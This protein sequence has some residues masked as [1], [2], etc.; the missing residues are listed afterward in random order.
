MKTPDEIRAM[1][2]SLLDE[3]GISMA[4]ASIAIGKNSAY[5]QQYI[6]KGSPVRLPEE[7]RKRLSIILDIPEQDL[8]DR[9]IIKIPMPSAFE[10]INMVA[11]S[12][13]GLFAPKTD[14]NDKVSINMYD[15]TACCGTGIE[16]LAE[17]V[18]GTWSM[19]MP[20]FKKISSTIPENVKL[21]KVKG[22]SMLPTLKEDD[23]VF[24]DVSQKEFT[25]DGIYL[26]RLTSGLA[27]KRIQSSVSDNIIILSDNPK[28]QAINVNISDAEIVGKVIHAFKSEKVG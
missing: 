24:V 11:N 12:L 18:I 4:S 7:Q 19:T 5:L 14:A 16:A 10:G 23:W 9:P 20:E 1:I 28:Y 15:V 17:N 22:D 8:T 21:I 26:I 25:I 3:R 13:G 2:K 27:V 6:V